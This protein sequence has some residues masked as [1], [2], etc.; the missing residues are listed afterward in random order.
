[1]VAVAAV[2]NNAIIIGGD[3]YQLCILVNN[4]ML[5]YVKFYQH[6]LTAVK[7][8]TSHVHEQNR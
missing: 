6:H 4:I 7:C 2:Y 8:Q 5:M 3:I 1:M